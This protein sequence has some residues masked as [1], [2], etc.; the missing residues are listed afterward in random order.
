LYQAV[1]GYGLFTGEKPN[2]ERMS[3]VI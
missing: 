1:T 2:L 3:D